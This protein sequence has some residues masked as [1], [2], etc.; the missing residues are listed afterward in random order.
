M[1]A[2]G[3]NDAGRS[4]DQRQST[5]SLISHIYRTLGIRLSAVKQG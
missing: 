3:Y 2:Q 1:Q 4:G 5:Q